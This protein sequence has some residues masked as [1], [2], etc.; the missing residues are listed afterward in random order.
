MAQ[1]FIRNQI[2]KDNTGTG[3]QVLIINSKRFR[4]RF[5]C[6]NGKK[7]HKDSDEQ[8]KTKKHSSAS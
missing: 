8:F 3:N 2:P 4:V 5:L 1:Q 6:T 7:T